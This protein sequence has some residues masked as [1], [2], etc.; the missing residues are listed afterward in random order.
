[1]KLTKETLKRIIKEEIE[2][3]RL[4][5]HRMQKKT[6]APQSTQPTSNFSEREIQKIINHPFMKYYLGAH[7]GGMSHDWRNAPAG[8]GITQNDLSEREFFN[9]VQNKLAD[10]N[11]DLTLAV[12][13]KMMEDGTLGE[14]FLM[15]IGR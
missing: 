7:F 15:A 3:S 9:I 11:E 4:R 13:K 12:V 5:R 14:E 10:G 2:E 1:M 8:S 6:Q